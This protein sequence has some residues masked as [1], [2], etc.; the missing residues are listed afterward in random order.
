MRFTDFYVAQAGL[1]GLARGAADRLL[2]EP[3]RHPR[4]ARA[5]VEGRHQRR[6]NDARPKFCKQRGY[7]TG[8]F[9]KWHLGTI[10][11]SCRRG[12]A[13]TNTSACPT[14]TTC[15]RI[16][17]TQGRRRRIPTCR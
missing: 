7:A 2:S 12:T 17:P 13:S 16:H 10:R 9:G 1:L 14:R 4:R 8:I 5:A 6:A 11:S 3:R 15:G